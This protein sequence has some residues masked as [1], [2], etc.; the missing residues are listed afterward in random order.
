MKGVDYMSTKPIN[1][2]VDEELKS[3]AEVLLK[4]MG[5]T[6]SSALNLFLQ[7]VVNK[8]ALPFIIEAPDPFYNDANQELLMNRLDK[9]K[10]GVKKDRKLIEVE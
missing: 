8:R 6:M 10:N 4:E 7:Q 3:D 1:F 9:Y 2:R 5:L